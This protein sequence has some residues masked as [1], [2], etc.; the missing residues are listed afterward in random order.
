MKLVS[1]RLQFGDP[2]YVGLPYWPERNDLINLSKDVH[3]KLGPAKKE[4]A[5]VAACEKRGWTKADYEAKLEKSM[6]PFYTDNDL[7][8]G[9]IV[10]PQRVIQSF[11]NNTSQECPKAIPRIASKGLTFVGIRVTDGKGGKF[12]RTG[13][14]EKDSLMFSRFVKLE[15]S[16]QR[17]W[18]ESAYIRDFTAEGIL[19]VDEEIIKCDDLKKLFEYGGRMY[20]V[21]SAR[22]Q[23]FGRFQVMSW[24]VIGDRKTPGMPVVEQLKEME[25]GA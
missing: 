13:K 24:T 9:M 19:E 18:S 20:G 4:A 14:F 15:N 25:L 8:T 7:R 16:N 10:I 11:L 6:H 22:P 23:G 12:L 5:I 3:A 17:S 1:V 2:G 21:G